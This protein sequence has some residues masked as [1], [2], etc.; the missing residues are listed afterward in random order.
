MADARC[1]PS[2][3]SVLAL[4]AALAACALVAAPAPASAAYT[5]HLDL[6]YDI[7]SPPAPSPAGQNQLDLYT[8]VGAKRGSRPVV[9]YVHGGGWQQGDKR[10]RIQRKADL[11]TGAGYVLASLNYRLSPRLTPTGDLDPSRVKFPAHPHDV[12]EAIGWL[13]RHVARYG[14][15]PTRIVLIGH[16]SGA[17]LVSLVAT[18]PRYLKA[19]GVAQREILGVVS[20]DTAAYDVSRQADPRRKGA[21]ALWNAFGT[22]DENAATGSW[23]AGSPLHWAEPS[24]PPFLLVIQ[25]AGTRARK[26][27]TR[28]MARALGQGSDSVLAVPLNHEGINRTLGAADP[29]LETTTVTGFIRDAISAARPVA[30]V[31]RHPRR[32]LRTQGGRARVVFTFRVKGTYLRLQCRRDHG[33][34]A[35]CRSRFAYRVRPGRHT[36]AVRALAPSGAPGPVARFS[37]AVRSAGSA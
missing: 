25:Q 15:D 31:R 26:N 6:S 2:A 11:F 30:S 16:S 10:N 36:L 29:T 27:E 12:G 21:R 22:P 9:V 7:D 18:D 37:F 20:L 4:A 8:P 23:L 14:G 13:H 3:P 33:R 34:F 17:H 1:E 35:A 32:R 28:R 5:R 19:Y 24:D